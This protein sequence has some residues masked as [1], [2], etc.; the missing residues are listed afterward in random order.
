MGYAGQGFAGFALGLKVYR[1]RGWQ[2][3]AIDIHT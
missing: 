3:K 2:L 1:Q